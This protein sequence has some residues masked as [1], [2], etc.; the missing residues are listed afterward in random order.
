MTREG[1]DEREALIAAYRE[2]LGLATIAVI[3]AAAGVRIVAP[4][5]QDH[6]AACAQ[7]GVHVRW[8]CRR[9][10]DAARVAALAAR[11]LRRE[12][13]DANRSARLS[14]AQEAVFAA[15]A[16]LAIALRSDADIAA[17]AMAVAARLVA[18]MRK[19]QQSGGLKSLNKA[20]RSYRIE[21]SGRGER[22]LRY[23]EWMRQYRQNLVRQV[24]STLRQI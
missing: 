22:V 19:Q 14:R 11:M 1:G 5:A 6:D 13:N 2:G 23:D 17:E 15:A 4:T 16:K 8:W 9:A 12:S 21:S 24:A 18:E 3:D 20:Y 7:D 10:D